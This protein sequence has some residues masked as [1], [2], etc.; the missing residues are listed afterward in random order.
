[1]VAG[2]LAQRLSALDHVGGC[3]AQQDKQ[4]EESEDSSGAQMT[5]IYTWDHEHQTST[6]PPASRSAY[7]LVGFAPLK[8]GGRASN[9]FVSNGR[10]LEC[11]DQVA[12]AVEDARSHDRR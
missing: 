4:E 6:A 11:D 8:R 9:E 10:D 12:W 2:D 3:T 1:M 5:L 7:P